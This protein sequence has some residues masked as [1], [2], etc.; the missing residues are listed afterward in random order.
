MG[1]VS[2]LACFFSAISFVTLAF[3][4]LLAVVGLVLVALAFFG[5]DYF[6]SVVFLALR[7]FLEA[8]SSA[9]L[10]AASSSSLTNCSSIFET[11]SL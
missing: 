11:F 10:A 7:F 3:F 4:V 5:V 9:C 1:F 8:R 6:F 2:F